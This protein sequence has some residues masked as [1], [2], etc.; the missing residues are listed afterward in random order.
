MTAL[1]LARQVAAVRED[2]K[3]LAEQSA[4]QSESRFRSLVQNT[5]DVIMILDKNL[6]VRYV[7]PS[8]ERSFGVAP[9][10]RIGQRL[11]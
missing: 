6:I 2:V 5:S 3:L 1:A 8:I 11:F 4:R 9:E 10:T 7:T